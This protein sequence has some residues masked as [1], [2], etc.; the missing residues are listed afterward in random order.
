MLLSQIPKMS[1]FDLY[2]L[3]YSIVSG[4]KGPM[5]KSLSNRVKM[6]EIKNPTG[7]AAGVRR[8]NDPVN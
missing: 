5:Q 3:D 8:T 6:S 1:H 2:Y 7:L 4:P